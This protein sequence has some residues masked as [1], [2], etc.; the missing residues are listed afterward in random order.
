MLKFGDSADGSL[1][2]HPRTI[3][4]GKTGGIVSAILKVF[5]TRKEDRQGFLFSNV[6]NYPAHILM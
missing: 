2:P 5:N 1:T 6:T 3:N 4:H